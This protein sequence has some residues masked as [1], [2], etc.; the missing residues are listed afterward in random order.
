MPYVRIRRFTITTD[1]QCFDEPCV[2][3]KLTCTIVHVFI[4]FINF[5]IVAAEFGR[6]TE[7]IEAFPVA[8]YTSFAFFLVTISYYSSFS[9]SFQ[10]DCYSPFE[11]KKTF[12]NDHEFVL[13]ILS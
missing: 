2:C 1:A 11:N 4:A 5:I 12:D 10:R 7:F 9:F 3:C 8:D 13:F 6:Q